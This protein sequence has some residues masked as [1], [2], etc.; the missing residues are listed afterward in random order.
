MPFPPYIRGS[1]VS[2]AAAWNSLRRCRSERIVGW[3]E[4]LV[5]RFYH[6]RPS[7]VFPSTATRLGESTVN[8]APQLVVDS[9]ESCPEATTLDPASRR[10]LDS[11][12]PATT[13]TNYSSLSPGYQSSGSQ[14]SSKHRT[15]KKVRDLLGHA[16]S[17]RRRAA[18]KMSEAHLQSP[19]TKRSRSADS[20]ASAQTASF[21]GEED[22]NM[23]SE[24]DGNKGDIP[25][26]LNL[27]ELEIRNKFIELDN[28]QTKRH[29]GEGAGTGTESRRCLL[30][31]TPQTMVRNRYMNIQ[32]WADSRIHLKVPEGECDYINASPISLQN[33]ETGEVARY[34]AAQGPKKEYLWDFWNMVFHETGDV[35]VLVMLTQVYEQMKEKCAQYFP[36][37]MQT[38]TYHF[39]RPPS[40]PFV[41]HNDG[42]EVDSAFAGQITLL[43]SIY[44]DDCRSEIRKLELTFGSQSK[45]VWHYL[46]AGW[47]DYS[48]PEGKD[49]NALVKLTQV[50]AAKAGSLSNPRIVHCSAGVGRTG[51][52][53]TIDHLM[54][55]MR[56]GNLLNIKNNDNNN[57]PDEEQPDPI[58]DTVNLLREQ[59][60]CMVYTEVQY[61]FIYDI[62]REQALLFLGRNPAQAKKSRSPGSRSQKMAKYSTNT[63]EPM[64]K[65]E[66]APIID[67]IPMP[68]RG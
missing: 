39:R 5:R 12:T 23:A 15:P 37:N 41:D 21:S 30:V 1:R 55:E 45:I 68:K 20:R 26:F 67:T 63:P 13:A 40:D 35:A 60:I 43:E 19:L 54:R 51:T 65:E 66:F 17:F 11:Q 16:K 58:F 6:L 4:V 29:L 36:L 34:I 62:L 49:R 48:K 27:S 57:E 18:A 59:R 52:F 53:I 10:S 56:T 46:F 61:Q 44:N 42:D 9:S 7:P 33:S 64:Q 28:R 38:P 32:V 14:G 50:T 3:T 24:E 8:L 31:E 22:S 47:S 25:S 2:S